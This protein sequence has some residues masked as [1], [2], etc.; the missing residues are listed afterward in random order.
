MT[1]MRPFVI[2]LRNFYRPKHKCEKNG[3]ISYNRI[4]LSS[5]QAYYKHDPSCLNNDGLTPLATRSIDFICPV[6][7]MLQACFEGNIT[8]VFK[9]QCFINCVKY[10]LW[11]ES[12]HLKK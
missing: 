2:T 1:T 3:V 9:R 8:P 10:V 7:A 12:C 6:T 4:T 5:D 11:K